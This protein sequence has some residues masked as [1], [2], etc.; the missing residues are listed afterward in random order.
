[1]KPAHPAVVA[2]AVALVAG[3]QAFAD[4]PETRKMLAMI[5]GIEFITRNSS[6]VYVG[7]ALPVVTVVGEHDLQLRFRASQMPAPAST[8]SRSG[9]RV[10][11]FFDRHANQIFLSDASAVTGPG[12]LHELV[13]FLQAINGKDDMFASHPVCLEAEAYDL[14]AIWQTEHAIDLASKPDY[15]FIMTLYGACNDADFSWVESAGPDKEDCGDAD[16]TC[17]RLSD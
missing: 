10:A 14:Q 8:S 15:G 17:G 1:M 16:P 3:G 11:A 2:A 4:G 13:H 12:L 9:G 6:L 5:A 7:E